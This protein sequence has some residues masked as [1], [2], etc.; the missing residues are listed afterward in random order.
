MK[1]RIPAAALRRIRDSE[2][3]EINIEE[4]IDCDGSACDRSFFDEDGELM[5][6][7]PHYH[8]IVIGKS[9]DSGPRCYA[10]GGDLPE[11]TYQP[12]HE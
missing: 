10:I 4:A 11:S 7:P 6:L 2:F 5:D 9:P 1:I 8:M 3:V 12:S